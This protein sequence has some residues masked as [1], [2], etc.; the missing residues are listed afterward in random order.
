MAEDTTPDATAPPPDPFLAW[1]RDTIQAH[2]ETYDPAHFS[3]AQARAW[4]PL[5][6]G[7]GFRSSKVD[8]HGNPIPGDSFTHPDEC[9]AG[10]AAWGPTACAPVGYHGG[11]G[12]GGGTSGGGGGGG[13]F[14]WEGYHPFDMAYPQFHLPSSEDVLSDPGYQFR[15]DQGRKSIEASAAA[16]GVL[17]TGGTLAGIG[18]YGQ[19][20][21]SS[22]YGSAFQRAKDVYGSKLGQYKS[23][24][25]QYVFGIDDEFRREQ[26][27]A[28]I[29]QPFGAY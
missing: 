18:K 20:Y 23:A 22:E 24:W 4:F 2:P 3:E 25:D 14:S 8:I 27:L 26:L 21:A 11:G 28:G 12:G 17:N 13:G 1:F 6:S 9:P 7:H 15:L 16:K 10:M 29:Q 19:D 5:W